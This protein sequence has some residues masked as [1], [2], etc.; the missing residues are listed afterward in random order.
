LQNSCES[1]IESKAI[2][3]K[4][5]KKGKS[6]GNNSDQLRAKLEDIKLQTKRVEVMLR[7]LEN[8]LITPESLEEVREDFEAYLKDHT[9]G[10]CRANWENVL[11][12]NIDVEI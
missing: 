9:N 5:A 6:K 12:I 8:E 3:T 11:K 7:S 2:V 1:E 10:T 4:K